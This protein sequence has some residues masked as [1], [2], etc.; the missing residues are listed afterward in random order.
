M[1]ERKDRGVPVRV[2]SV[3]FIDLPV[4]R[5]VLSR[6]FH[7]VVGVHRQPPSVDW[8]IVGRSDFNLRGKNLGNI[9]LDI[10]K[11]NTV[12]KLGNDGS[13]MIPSRDEKGLRRIL[14]SDPHSLPDNIFHQIELFTPRK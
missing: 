8:Y 4:E 7:L 9:Q 6:F 2:H 1:S 3:F 5:G 13:I 10:G 11:S 14:V 12:G